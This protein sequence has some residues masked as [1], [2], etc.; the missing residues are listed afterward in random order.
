MRVV[1]NISEFLRNR[2]PDREQTLSVIAGT[3]AGITCGIA[4]YLFTS[5][6]NFEPNPVNVG[7]G[8]GVAFPVTFLTTSIIPAI[9]QEIQRRQPNN[10]IS[11]NDN[12]VSV[13]LVID[14][15]SNQ[16]AR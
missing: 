14:Q 9:V 4:A 1:S 5:N 11:S 13:E 12:Q 10:A 16:L 3:T 15:G 2:M 6:N 8:A 7:V